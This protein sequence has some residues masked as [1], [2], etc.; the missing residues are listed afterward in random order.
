MSCELVSLVLHMLT[1]CVDLCRN[2]MW[3][4]VCSFPHKS[5]SVTC[6]QLGYSPHGE[7]N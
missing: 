2:R 6:R 4:R 5:G 1:G 3:H 7:T